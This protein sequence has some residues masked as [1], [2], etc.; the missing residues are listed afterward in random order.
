[1]NP[2]SLYRSSDS[3]FDAHQ[4]CI[5]ASTHHLPLPSLFLSKHH[6]Q[7]SSERLFVNATEVGGGFG[8]P[9]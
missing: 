2:L 6:R 4:I 5:N 3:R 1:M 9:A 7:K 8:F